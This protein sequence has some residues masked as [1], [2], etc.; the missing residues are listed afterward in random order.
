MTP[1]V[2]R[3]S[4]SACALAL[5]CAASAATPG[6]APPNL[7]AGLRQM[8]EA[9]QS[10]ALAA[11]MLSPA[12]LAAQLSNL[13]G[14]KHASLDE[15][16]R[17]LVDIYA[18]GK[19]G[20]YALRDRVTRLD[21][22]VIEVYPGYRKGVISAYVP[23]ARMAELAR[24]IGV[25]N[26]ALVPRPVT[27]VG[28]T[29][30]QGGTV[31]R[32]DLVNDAGITGAGVTVGVMSDSYNTSS[33]SSKSAKDDVASGDLPNLQ[34]GNAKSP[35]VKFLI[36]PSRLLGLLSTDEG[37]GMAQIVHDVAPGADL[38]FATANSTPAT[39]ARNI[40]TLRTNPKCNADVIVDDIIYLTE[41]MFSDGIIAQ[42]VDDVVNSTTLAGKRVSYFSSAGNRG[43]GYTDRF[44][45]VSPAD[46]A[47]IDASDPTIDL[48]TVPASV[49]TSG[50]FQDFDDGPGVD[51]SQQLT[52]SGAACTVVFQWND[53]FDLPG[54]ITTDYNFLVFNSAGKYVAN[55][56]LTDDNF[57]TSQP[58]ETSATDLAAD[59]TYSIVIART[60]RGS[61]E[62][63][64]LKYV[65][66]GGTMSA[67]YN[68]G[69]GKDASTYGHNSA[70]G[71]NGVAAYIY[72]DVPVTTPPFDTFSPSLEGFSSS[73]PALIFFDADGNR[74]PQADRRKRPNIAAPD[75]VNTTF[76]PPGPLASTDYEGDGFP[77]FFGTSAAAPHAAGVA[78]LMIEA[79]GGPGTLSSQALRNA[80]QSTTPPRDADP[81]F[82]SIRDAGSLVQFSATGTLSTD[83]NFFR[84]DF[85]GADLMLNA[86]TIDLTP[87]GLQFDPSATTGFPLTV[88]STTGPVITSPP[89]T[90]TTQVL[91]LKFSGF[92]S[93]NS[94]TFGIDRDIALLAAYGNSADL[95]GGAVI[96]YSYS[97]PDGSG[98]MTV[99]K[100]MSNRIGDSYVLDDGF[101]LIDAAKAV[102]A[103]AP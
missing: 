44:R 57:A 75:G 42:A 18:D 28:A 71:G 21:A 82:S 23:L 83:P 54:G 101:G 76:F 48:S 40:R 64:T 35:G 15:R 93:G 95:L 99:S 37:R 32:S 5:A 41:P 49:D 19:L 55:L 33:Q 98:K 16:N 12:Q 69:K 81:T 3:L 79:A 43:T 70:A 89:P 96:T 9:N 25:S 6:S 74:L 36:E 1:F 34:N 30:S 29:T 53:P 22:D 80:L 88:G 20:L 97:K 62:A 60:G 91:K 24:N 100:T 59:T 85:G 58:L 90:T 103:V 52:C 8:V 61:G 92:A 31:M 10:A 11:G 78:A 102:K 87:T 65:L 73:G 27:N 94:L 46:A 67:E 39:F 26:V 45:V 2:I 86:L 84:I 66:F 17:V 14:M 56:S 68:E 51:I 47:V 77:N 13:P 38:C 72:D 7:S 63:T 4:V 50:G